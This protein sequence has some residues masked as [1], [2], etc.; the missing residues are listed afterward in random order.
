MA[1][2]PGKKNCSMQKI[3]VLIVFT[4]TGIP[5]NK[6]PRAGFNITFANMNRER[7]CSAGNNCRN[8]KFAYFK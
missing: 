2:Y 6:G 7:R 1:D 8:R 3:Q 4:I 5:K